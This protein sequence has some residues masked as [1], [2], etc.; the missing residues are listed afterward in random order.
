MPGIQ[1]AAYRG[2]A[3][4]FSLAALV[5]F[6]LAANPVAQPKTAAVARQAVDAS[7]RSGKG[8]V[9]IVAAATS[10]NPA[11][12]AYGDWADNFRRFLA[13]APADVRVVRMTPALFKR[14][15]DEPSLKEQFAAVFIRDEKHAA[16]YDGAIVEQ[17]VYKLGSKYITE[18]GIQDDRRFADSGLREIE[19]RLKKK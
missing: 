18:G 16:L 11:D 2:A 1:C 7:L 6:S 4:V 15:F 13:T 9:I 17:Q 5:V 19:I 12:E 14:C 3:R 8:V 10:V